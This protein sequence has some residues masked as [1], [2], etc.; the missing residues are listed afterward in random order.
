M[1]E[2]KFTPGG[3]SELRYARM[4]DKFFIETTKG[5]HVTDYILDEGY[6]KLF[7]AAPD[8]YAACVDVLA[9]L[10]NEY[11]PHTVDVNWPTLRAAT[12]RVRG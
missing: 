6:A 8:L 4:G 10:D 1:S 5:H 12:A 3:R 7:A 9:G 2:A 11:G